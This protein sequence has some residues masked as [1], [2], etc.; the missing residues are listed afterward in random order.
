MISLH[1]FNHKNGEMKDLKGYLR[2]YSFRWPTFTQ[3][4]HNKNDNLKTYDT[5]GSA[6]SILSQQKQ[7]VHIP[8]SFR[9]HHHYFVFKAGVLLSTLFLFFLTTTLVSFTLCETQD[10]MLVFTVQLQ[11]LIRSRRPYASL[12]ARHVVESMVFVPIMIGIVFFLMDCFYNGDKFLA[13]IILSGV[14][15]CEVFSVIR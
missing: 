4:D 12:I 1:I 10:R 13:F 8:S 3:T 11:L 5:D 7:P 9:W 15:I 2:E 6:S 14:W